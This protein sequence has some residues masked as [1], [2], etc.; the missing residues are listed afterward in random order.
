MM[1]RRT[2]FQVG[3]G[4]VGALAV[5]VLPRKTWA[6]GALPELTEDDGLAKTLGY[7]QDASKVDVKKWPKKAGKDGKAQNCANCMFYAKVD[8]KVG[9]CTIFAGKSVRGAGWCNS[10]AKKAG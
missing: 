10:W 2:F 5:A 3:L 6:Q 8:G 1:K 9:K 7:Y 4:M